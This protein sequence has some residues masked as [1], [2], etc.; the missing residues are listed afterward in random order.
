MTHSSVVEVV[1]GTGGEDAADFARMLR[2]MYAAWNGPVDGEQGLHR[3]VRLSPFDE[4]HRRHTAFAKVVVDGD[5]GADKGGMT[6]S[7]VLHPYTLVT[8]Y[9]FAK[10][11]VEVERVLAGELQLIRYGD[12]WGPPARLPAPA[13][14]DP[15]STKGKA[16]IARGR[17]LAEEHGW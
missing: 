8:D 3:L 13:P 6:R 16:D 5:D 2:E 4:A 1:A 10:A 12:D 17:Q 14:F 15:E 9:H 7:Y 11:T